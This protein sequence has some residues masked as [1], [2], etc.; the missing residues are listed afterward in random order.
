MC[1]A[2]WRPSRAA[3]VRG[4][5]REGRLGC[6]AIRLRV[7]L[8]APM[9][10]EYGHDR[11]RKLLLLVMKGDVSDDDLLFYA[12]KAVADPDID[13]ETNDY[14]DLSGVTST[15][16]TSAGLQRMNAALEQGGRVRHSGRMAIYAPDDVPFGLARMFQAYREGTPIEVRVFRQADE[17]REWIGLDA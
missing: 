17:A 3:W 12:E 10:I 13:A 9:S 4:E 8:A 1:D 11:E 5:P 16:V 15:S 2:V 7:T 14:I 6:E